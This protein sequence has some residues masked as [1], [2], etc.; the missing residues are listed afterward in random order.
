MKLIFVIAFILPFSMAALSSVK[1]FMYVMKS[2]DWIKEPNFLNNK[3]LKGAQVIYSWREL[4]P[5][6]DEYDF[7]KIEKDIRILAKH[8]KKLFIQLQDVSFFK[9]FK[10]VPD[11]ILK[12]EYDGGVTVQKGYNADNSGWMSIRWNEQVRRRFQTLI[13][14]LGERFDGEVEG[15]NLQESAFSIEDIEK[16]PSGYSH[17]LYRDSLLDTMKALSQGF[18]KSQAVQYAN[19]MPGEWLPWKN[20]GYLES[21]YAEGEKLNICM[22]S[23]DLIPNR[24]SYINHAYKLM[25]GLDKKS[26]KAIAIQNGNYI[27]KTATSISAQ[28]LNKV[29]SLY[30]FA[31]ED[32]K[33]SYIFWVKQ[34]PYFTSFVIPFLSKKQK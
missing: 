10:P 18:K 17:S 16:L 31:K 25:R 5:E 11:Y 1:N 20:K 4:E 19:F 6:K 9:K 22:G 29:S 34:E 24:K 14:K 13:L 32:L 21:L 27:G 2:R 3:A 33:V 28:T 12:P 15:I 8:N 26:C 7:S 23:P 30:T